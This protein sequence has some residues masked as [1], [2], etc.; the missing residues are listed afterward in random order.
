MDKQNIKKL[1]INEDAF[2]KLS[3]RKKILEQGT[4]HFTGYPSIDMPWL[5]YYTEEQIMAPIPHMS[6]YDYLRLCNSNNLRNIAMQ[7]GDETITFKDMF[8]KITETSK[9]LVALGVKPGEIV[10]IVLPARNR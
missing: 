10:S 6:C 4:G 5:K 9:A 2:L 3:K 8:K 1:R 7:F